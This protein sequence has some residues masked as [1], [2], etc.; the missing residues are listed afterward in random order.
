MEL[1]EGCRLIRD[2]AAN[3]AKPCRMHKA[4][5]RLNWEGIWVIECTK[6]C[7]IHTVDLRPHDLI[8]RYRATP[9]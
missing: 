5:A 4:P 6:G 9:F 2:F 1:T 8:V 7:S 3:F